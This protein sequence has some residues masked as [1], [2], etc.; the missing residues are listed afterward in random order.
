MA[1]E[2]PL[3][4]LAP[5]DVVA[6]AIS[7]R[8]NER[9]ARPPLARRHRDRRLRARASRR[10]GRRAGSS[11]SIPP[12]TGC[13]W[14]PPRT[15][16]PA[17]CAPTS[18][19]RRRF[20]GCGRAARPRAPACTAPTGSRRT[21]CS[22]AW[23]SRRA[24]SR[25]SCR[26]ATAPS[27][28]VCSAS[29]RRD[30]APS[31]DAERRSRPGPALHPRGAAADHDARRRR[32]AQRRE[33]RP[34]RRRARRDGPTDVESANLLAVSTASR[35]R[36][37]ARA[38]SR[39]ARTP[40]S[41]HPEP[42]PEFL[43]RLVFSGDGATRVRPA[44]DRTR[45][46]A[47]SEHDAPVARRARAR[48]HGAGRGP[49][50][51]R[52][53]HRRARTRRRARVR[54]RRRPGRRRARR[55]RVRDRGVRAARPVGAGALAVDDGDVVGPGT[56]VGEVAGPLRSVLTGERSALNFLCHLSGVASAHPPLRRRRRPDGPDLGHPQDAARAPRGR[57]GGGPRRRG[58]EPPRLALG[59]RAGE[60]Q[61]P[62]R[63]Q[64]HRG[65]RAGRAHAGPAA[66]S[67]WSATAP[68]RCRRRSPRAPTMVL[69]DNM[70]PDAVRACVSLVRT[71]APAGFLVEVSGGV[72][73]DNVRAYA[74]AGA[75]LI[76]TSVITQSAPALDIALRPDDLDRGG[77][78]DA[79]R[80][81]LWQHPDRH[82]PLQRPRARRPLAHRDR[83]RPHVRRARADVPAVPRV[84]RVLVR[85][86]RLGRR[87]RVGRPARHR[88]APRDDRALLRL[89]G[90]RARTRCTHRHADPLRR[91]QERRCRPHR[92]RRGR[93][94]PLRRPDHRRRLRHRQHRRRGEREG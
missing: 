38:V 34:R 88:R 50:P 36:G 3:A 43:G 13:R 59:V 10:S 45:A 94:R 28:P 11:A 75:D 48:R 83:R 70:T 20:P 66:R 57:E 64:H 65:G 39:A 53:P 47:M 80:D 1:D 9:D 78:N 76:S 68:S 86:A 19:A 93:L 77:L 15:T 61:P 41:T 71:T 6:R 82:R 81:R 2:H 90:A 60:G 79:A 32:P 23:C 44:R 54:R 4:D 51:A 49:R 21:R 25:R 35:P 84:P 87:H 52:R 18:T 22:R 67:R 56:K 33:P 37:D 31:F 89:P 40:A 73:L 17:A 12:A 27:R 63:A 91:A 14:R 16:S 74:D 92:Q 7:R 29:R 5:R 42:S 46:V 30:V 69:L 58:R 55:H 62:R 8:L 72:T 24:R 26:D 85:R